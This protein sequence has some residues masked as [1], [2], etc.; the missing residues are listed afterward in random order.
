MNKKL[1]TVE[2][3]H[4]IPKYGLRKGDMGEI[5]HRFKDR[6][7]FGIGFVAAEGMTVTLLT[8]NSTDIRQINSEGSRASARDFL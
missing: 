1:E 8:L 7:A 5:L 2:L 6:D 4:D 3:I